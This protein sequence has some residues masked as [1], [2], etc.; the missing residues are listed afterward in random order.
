MDMTEFLDFNNVPWEVAP[1]PPA[2]AVDGTCDY[3]KLK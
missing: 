3:Q 2:Q 1:S